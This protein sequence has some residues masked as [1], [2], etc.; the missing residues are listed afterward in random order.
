MTQLYICNYLTSAYLT[1]CV[2]GPPPTLKR[3]IQFRRKKLKSVDISRPTTRTFQ[4]IFNGKG[5]RPMLQQFALAGTAVRYNSL[6][7]CSKRRTGITKKIS[8]APRCLGLRSSPVNS[9][10]HERKTAQ[11]LVASRRMA[12]LQPPVFASSI[13]AAGSESFGGP[14]LNI[15]TL[16]TLIRVAAVP[17]VT[18]IFFLQGAWVAPTC[19]TIFIFAAVTDW[20]DG[21]LARKMG[22][23][24]SFGAFLD[25][26]ADKLM[27]AAALVL[28][29]VHG[30]PNVG[31]ALIAIP[32]TIIIGREITM[33]ALREWAAS[34]G[35][36]VHDAV[37]V[38]S[39]GKWKTATQL[40]ALSILLG[41]RDG[42][43][44]L[45]LSTDAGVLLTKGGSCC[46]WL[47][48]GLALLS[49]YIYI[50]QAL[51]SI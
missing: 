2:F 35:G 43:A 41:A 24:S 34:A 1:C 13:D 49:L 25:P 6:T 16:L 36:E 40:V 30:P 47:S 46:L 39:F 26:V 22:L 3:N 44:W 21:F 15:P 12:D 23:V 27:V 42:F 51:S 31:G 5:V 28:L 19:C 8:H 7:R 20:A 37:A 17:L 9:V 50:C 14:T 11:F 45:G 10:F 29:C 32:A 48:A 4:L 18:F 33:S 38:N